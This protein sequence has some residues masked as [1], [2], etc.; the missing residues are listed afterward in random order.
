MM[1]VV[2]TG[3]SIHGVAPKIVIYNGETTHQRGLGYTIN[4]QSHTITV[5]YVYRWLVTVTSDGELYGK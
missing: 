5:V 2:Y 4:G 3:L 1:V